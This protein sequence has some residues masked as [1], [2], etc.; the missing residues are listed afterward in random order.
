MPRTECCHPDLC[1]EFP[2]A[3]AGSAF[4]HAIRQRKLRIPNVEKKEPKSLRFFTKKYI[5]RH[6]WQHGGISAAW[7]IPRICQRVLSCSLI[8]WKWEEIAIKN[9]CRT[10]SKTS[11]MSL[12]KLLV[13]LTLTNLKYILVQNTNRH[14]DCYSERRLPKSQPSKTKDT[15][16]AQESLQLK[17]RRL[18]QGKG[19][20]WQG[21]LV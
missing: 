6:K 15:V 9:K 10:S 1:L 12:F 3:A 8:S 17:P 5:S 19:R 7:R 2:A 16:S 14:K 4:S 20:Q 13:I 18:K 11:V 21:L